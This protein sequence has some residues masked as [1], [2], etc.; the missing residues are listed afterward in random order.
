[1]CRSHILEPLPARAPVRHAVRANRLLRPL[2]VRLLDVL[3]QSLRA[4]EVLVDLR[5][6][7]LLRFAVLL[8]WIALASAR[9][10][11]QARA[12]TYI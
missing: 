9:P 1:M 4:R 10:R 2:L 3:L 5:L 11:A 8:I 7:E 6:D 12:R